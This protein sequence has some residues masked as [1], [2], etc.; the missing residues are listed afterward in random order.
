MQKTAFQLSLILIFSIPW[1]NAI[2]I[3]TFG[4]LT[5]VLGLAAAI[6]CFG[7]GLEIGYRK[8]NIYHLLVGI[9]I[10][11]NITSCFWSHDKDVTIQR[12]KTYIQLGVLSWMI[13]ELLTEMQSLGAALQAYILGSYVA[14][15]S[16]LFNYFSGVTI[17]EYEY[18]RFAGAGLDAVDQALIL[19]L[20]LPMA[21]YLSTA[22]AFRKKT[23][24]LKIANW[25][26]IPIS[27]FAVILTGS[28]TGIIVCLP[29][30]LYIIYTSGRFRTI[31][32]AVI[33]LAIFLTTI[34]ASFHVPAK[35]IERLLT[36]KDS[37]TQKDIGG[38]VHLW[39]ESKK[40][41]VSNP[42]LGI[43]S[44]ALLSDNRLNSVSH[45]TLL[46]IM[47]ELGIIGLTAFIA[48]LVVVFNRILK[49]PSGLNTLWLTV[50]IIWMLGTLG[51]TWEFRKPTWLLLNLIIASAHLSSSTP[52]QKVI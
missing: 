18:G 45:N 10:L 21:W 11:W 49:Q 43:G 22:E 38:R 33:Y 19:T 44:G 6:A 4:T 20:G 23:I 16:T 41:F 40:V 51:L 8:L 31:S 29:S 12:I 32:R 25:V 50:F 48:I 28:R 37:I 46:S 47:G 35:T 27:L 2:V 5:R 39:Q 36:V 14:I 24:Y 7:A 52:K 15:I 26:Y 3:G 34:F 13:W 30:L 42:L 9:F 17:S 1:E